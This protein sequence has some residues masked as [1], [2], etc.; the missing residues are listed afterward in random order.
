MIMINLWNWEHCDELLE[1][2]RMFGPVD[3]QWFYDNFYTVKFN[4]IHMDR[5]SEDSSFIIQDVSSQ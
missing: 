1:E 4:L 2:G 3:D 5:I